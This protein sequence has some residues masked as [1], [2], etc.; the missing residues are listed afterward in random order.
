VTFDIKEIG[1]ILTY[2]LDLKQGFDVLQ[3]TWLT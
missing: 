3:D 2:N 1:Q